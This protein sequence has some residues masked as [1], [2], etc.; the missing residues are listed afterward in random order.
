MIMGFYFSPLSDER[1]S[2]VIEQKSVGE[3]KYL[4][5]RLVD[6]ESLWV[7][8]FLHLPNLD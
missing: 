5:H 7:C 1:K 3:K 2:I 6:R 4:K 8:V